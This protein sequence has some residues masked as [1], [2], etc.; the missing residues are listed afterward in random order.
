MADTSVYLLDLFALLA[1]S[2][3]SPGLNTQQPLVAHVDDSCGDDGDAENC[4]FGVKVFFV[5][6]DQEQ[7]REKYCRFRV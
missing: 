3:L 2:W 1:L 4:G 5:R 6:S 7:A